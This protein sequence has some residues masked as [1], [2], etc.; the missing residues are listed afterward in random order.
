MNGQPV[1]VFTIL[2]LVVAVIA[3]MRLKNVLGR[4]TGEDDE[5]VQRRTREANQ[6]RD[7]A[8]QSDKVV[9]LPRRDREPDREQPALGLPEP[10]NAQVVSN[11]IRAIGGETPLTEH[12]MEIVKADPDFEPDQFA[13][14]A[15]RAY[16]MIVTAFAEGNRKGLRD[17][18]SPAVYEEFARAISDRETRQEKIDQTFVGINKA[19][20][21]DAEIDRGN[22]QVT[23]R[24]VS[25]LITATR[26]KIG[27]VVSG[28]PAKV[29]DVTDLW[30]FSRDVSSSTARRNPNWKLVSTKHSN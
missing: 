19:D 25:Q 18:L 21:I 22:A 12:L 24:F 8:T 10:D 7:P 4:R 16:E 23:M 28:D 3:V 30:T 20:I 13:T 29:K 9:T 11:R 5:R 26:N 2:T 15:K 27:E 17:L 1:D 14:G 6:Q